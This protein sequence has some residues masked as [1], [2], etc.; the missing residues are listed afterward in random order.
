MDIEEDGYEIRF[1][2]YS[3]SKVPEHLAPT[4]FRGA[5]MC[6][7]AESLT[8]ARMKRPAFAGD[9]FLGFELSCATMMELLGLVFLIIEIGINI[10]DI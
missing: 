10:A 2:G 4:F 1:N 3:V 8:T 9:D 5:Y 7:D 6:F